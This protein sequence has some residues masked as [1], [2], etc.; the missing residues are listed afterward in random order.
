MGGTPVR[1]HEPA[2]SP[3]FQGVLEEFRS[4]LRSEPLSVA[5]LVSGMLDL[6]ASPPE[7]NDLAQP[8]LLDLVEAFD[9]RLC[10]RDDRRPDC[11]RHLDE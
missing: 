10:R 2:L 5:F 3:E 6:M 8:S 7:E 11:H 1:R 9:E 4:A